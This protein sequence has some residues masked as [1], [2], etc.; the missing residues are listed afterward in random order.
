M[1]SETGAALCDGVV[2]DPTQPSERGALPSEGNQGDERDAYVTLGRTT[3]T[4][5]GSTYGA[6]APGWRSAHSSRGS[7]DPPRGTGEPSTGRR[8]IGGWTSKSREV[9]VMQSA[10]TVL[11]VL[12]EI[13][14]GQP[15]SRHSH[16]RARRSETVTPGSGER[17]LE[18]D[19]P[20][21]LASV[22]ISPCSKHTRAS[23]RGGQKD[24]PALEAHRP[25]R[26]AQLRSPQQEPLCPVTRYYAAGPEIPAG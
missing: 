1:A 11:G 14:G 2:S 5:A 26:P 8:G 18:K 21:H 24:K 13:P 23:R 10:E 17:T 15:R 12:R 22:P 16:W 7:N 25:K 20:R 9:C 6:R 3:G 4:N 19:P